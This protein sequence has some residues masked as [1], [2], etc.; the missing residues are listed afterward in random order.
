MR[1]LV[2]LPSP[3]FSKLPDTTETASEPVKG[4][5]SYCFSVKEN[6]ISA[7]RKERLLARNLVFRAWK[8]SKQKFPDRQA[9]VDV[10]KVHLSQCANPLKTDSTR[11]VHF[12]VQDTINLYQGWWSPGESDTPL[13]RL[14]VEIILILAVWRH[15]GTG[16]LRPR[17]TI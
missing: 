10:G 14:S 4:R 13:S 16:E 5:R 8:A 12:P 15:C 1:Q 6:P 3:L 7:S 17:F 9:G 2:A 11:G